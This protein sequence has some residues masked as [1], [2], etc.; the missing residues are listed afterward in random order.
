M[1]L[2]GLTHGTYIADKDNMARVTVALWLAVLAHPYYL[3]GV[4]CFALD[5]L[6]LWKRCPDAA[7]TEAPR[8]KGTDATATST[9]TTPTKIYTP[10][11]R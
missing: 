2:T 3:H 7:L 10:S 5:Q 9:L 1:P 11:S 4:A 6:S 8:D